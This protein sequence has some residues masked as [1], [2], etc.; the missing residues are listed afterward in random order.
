M[1]FR[2]ITNVKYQEFKNSWYYITYPNVREH[3]YAIN[4]CGDIIILTKNREKMKQVDF[5]HG[6]PVHSLLDN[7]YSGSYIKVF[8]SRLVAWEFVGHP[9]NF[10]QLQVN[11]VN[12]NFYNNYYKNLEWVTAEENNIHKKIYRLS[13]QGEHHGYSKHKEV[14][15][16]DIIQLIDDGLGAPDIAVYILKKFP[17]YYDDNKNNYD[18]IRGLVSKINRG[19]SWYNIKNDLKGSTTIENITFEKHIGEEVSRV[20]LHPIEVNYRKSGHIYIW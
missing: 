12:G 10:N 19:T 17:K 3:H 15:V 6:R 1:I 7:S 20:G 5:R 18:R 16:K 4:L 8:T 14:V 13:A 11:H 2:N 9:E